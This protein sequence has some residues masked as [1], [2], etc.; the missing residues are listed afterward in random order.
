MLD[1]LT[2]VAVFVVLVVW[3]VWGFGGDTLVEELAELF[4]LP[5]TAAALLVSAIVGLAGTFVVL[6]VDVC[7]RKRKSTDEESGVIS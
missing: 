3:S 7:K 1:L 4:G 5:F 6:E 2:A